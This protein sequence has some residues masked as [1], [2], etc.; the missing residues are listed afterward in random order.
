MSHEQIIKEIIIPPLT[1][2]FKTR[3]S[4]PQDWLRT[5]D[6]A[7]ILVLSTSYN[8]GSIGQACTKS[9]ILLTIFNECYIKIMVPVIF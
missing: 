6:P 1:Q 5:R 8:H 3:S 7:R 2:K 9:I 4:S